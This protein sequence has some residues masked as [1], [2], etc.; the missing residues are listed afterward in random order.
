MMAP[1]AWATGP[2]KR[3]REDDYAD[4]AMGGVSGFSEHR[5]KRQQILPVRTSPTAKR[6]MS[7]PSFP[8][9]DPQPVVSGY[10]Y[11]GAP[12]ISDHN[13]PAV[14]EQ[15]V[16]AAEPELPSN[17]SPDSMDMEMMDCEPEPR[18]PELQQQ[19]QQ[20]Q[21]LQPG[22]FQPDHLAPEPSISE[23]IPTPIHCSFAEQGRGKHWGGAAGNIT[24][25]HR[26]SYGVPPPT[27]QHHEPSVSLLGHESVPRSLDGA[28]AT[29]QV[30]EDWSMVQNRRLPSPISEVGGDM[31]DSGMGESPRMIL[32]SYHAGHQH[33]HDHD[34]C[35]DQQNQFPRQRLSSLDQLTHSHPL[36]SAMPLRNS[37]LNSQMGPR[38]P[39][40]IPQGEYQSHGHSHGHSHGSFDG[41]EIDMGSPQTSPKTT[42]PPNKR[43]H[44]RSKH[45]VSSWTMANQ[46]GMKRSFSIGYRDDCEKCRLKVPGHFN[47]IIVS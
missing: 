7:T 4:A 32:E 37:S 2:R 6:W 43:G 26:G 3:S 35:N 28:A 38:E 13:D 44:Q 10:Q 41:V 11:Y 17:Y 42:S 23:R 1:H 21:Y 22:N 46:P 47:H 33:H 31:E 30:M 16:W 24:M 19:H 34:H 27:Q 5:T 8:Q 29:A 20:Q 14:T 36:L 12:D 39:T 25:D 9:E 18:H 15:H 45:T 40:P